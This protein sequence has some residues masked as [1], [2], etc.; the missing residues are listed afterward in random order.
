MIP[1]HIVAL[2]GALLVGGGATAL[3]VRADAPRGRVVT[4]PHTPLSDA[5]TRG[6]IDAPVIVEVFFSAGSELGNQAYR[7]ALAL[8][9]RHPTRV[10]LVFRTLLRSDASQYVAPVA[11]AAH[12]RG[13]FFAFM[14][15]LVALSG[16]QP[17][18]EAV[19][20]AAAR[21]G[22][23]RAVAAAAITDDAIKRV[24]RANDGPAERARVGQRADLV[25]NGVAIGP[26]PDEGTL[27]TH[28]RTAL[29]IARLEL[30]AGAPAVALP[31]LHARRARCREARDRPRPFGDDRTGDDDEGLRELERA[32][33]AGWHLGRL[34]RDG[35]GCQPESTPTG[36]VDQAFDFELSRKP[37][38]G[39]LLTAPLSTAGLAGCGPAEAPVVVHVICNLRTTTCTDQLERARKV[40]N[41][42]FPSVRVVYRPWADLDGEGAAFDLPMAQAATCAQRLGD[43]WKFVMALRGLDRDQASL[44]GPAT[45]AGVAP[46]ALAACVD[47]NRDQARRLVAA[48]RAAGVAWSPTVVIGQRAYVGGLTDARPMED[49]IDAELAPGLLG[50]TADAGLPPAP[51][52]GVNTCD[53]AHD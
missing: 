21:A 43:G 32:P 46:D 37:P 1:R 49:L 53:D 23:D 25:V 47:G 40:A 34:L 30:A 11:M 9:R 15:E 38:R 50:A 13:R 45:H 3:V 29:A 5:P 52:P 41:L 28:Y 6:P 16:P 48:A 44:D 2:A 35:T 33:L 20:D 39:A 12:A 7:R 42:Y 18:G 8:W 19:L 14:D 4:V 31:A 26:T 51:P 36:R 22:L 24:L 10:R 17:G 27:E